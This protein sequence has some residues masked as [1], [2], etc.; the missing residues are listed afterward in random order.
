V[1]PTGSGKTTTLHSG[2][3][4]INTPER[5][6][7]TAEDPVEITQEGMRQLQVKP[8][9]GLS[10]AAALRSFLR[11]DPD[12]IMIGEMRDEETAQIGVECSLTGH[13]VFST[14]H[15]NS[16]AETVSRLLDMGLDSFNFADSLKCVLAQR[17]MK[18]LCP[19]C[20]EPYNPSKSEFEET[21][22]EFGPL[23]EER[24]KLSHSKEITFYRAKGCPD[25]VGGYKGRIGVHEL[26]V[27]SEGLK[28]LIKYR[29]PTEE[30]RDLA[31][32][33]GML[34]LKQDGILKVIQGVSDLKQVHATAG[35]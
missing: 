8:K 22:S 30:I 21:V 35:H 33:E 12:V 32:R 4:Y 9:I 23:W 27:V 11:S 28:T 31:I 2:L 1:G 19:K 3:S 17:L 16:A 34:T 5:K 29:K 15:T 13:L 20:K 18:T 6:I 24:V 26:L 7:L 10:F 25:C 14:L